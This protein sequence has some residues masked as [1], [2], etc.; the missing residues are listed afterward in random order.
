MQK[1]S[2]APTN[3]FF[4]HRLVGLSGTDQVV[5]ICAMLSVNNSIF[6]TQAPQYF[7]EILAMDGLGGI[8]ISVIF[9][10]LKNH[11]FL[12]ARLVKMS[13]RPF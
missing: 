9:L 5:T 10:C 12:R 4:I 7:Q 13:G 3:S 1:K 2:C 8:S 11:L 6:Y